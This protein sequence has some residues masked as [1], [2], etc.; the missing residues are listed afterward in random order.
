LFEWVTGKVQTTLPVLLL[1]SEWSTGQRIEFLYF[2]GAAMRS[3]ELRRARGHTCALNPAQPAG[4]EETRGI[5]I[6]FDDMLI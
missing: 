6:I 4:S 3:F 5:V 2:A 1:Q